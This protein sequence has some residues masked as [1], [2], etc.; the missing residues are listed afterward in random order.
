MIIGKSHKLISIPAKKTKRV[1]F[2]IKIPSKGINGVVLGG[3]N[4]TQKHKSSDN[5]LYSNAI[6]LKENDI[7]NRLK[8][9]DIKNIKPN[10]NQLE[11]E[12]INNQNSLATGYKFKLSVFNENKDK[13]ISAN[14]NYGMVPNSEESYKLNY[15]NLSPGFYSMK[16][17]LIDKNGRKKTYIKYFSINGKDKSKEYQNY[18]LIFLLAILITIIYYLG[19]LLLKRLKN[20]F[21]RC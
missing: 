10:I 5:I 18:L 12:M 6:L 2:K 16:V 17:N 14:K 20:N 21:R 13:V 9:L 15:E 7:N 8:N 1:S 11:L 3:I 19:V 4:T